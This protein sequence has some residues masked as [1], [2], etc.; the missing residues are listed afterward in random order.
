MNTAGSAADTAHPGAE[1]EGKSVADKLHQH[2]LVPGELV[3]AIGAADQ[4]V[5]AVNE[6]TQHHQSDRRQHSARA[7]ILQRLEDVIPV[8]L[9]GVYPHQHYYAQQKYPGDDFLAPGQPTVLRI[10]AE[11]LAVPSAMAHEG[12][13]KIHGFTPPFSGS[14]RSWVSISGCTGAGTS[15]SFGVCAGNQPTQAGKWR[16]K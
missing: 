11:F 5:D 4:I 16:R 7:I 12:R 8:Y 14:V 13:G 9:T 6:V 3:A 2:H 15:A 1:R 10:A